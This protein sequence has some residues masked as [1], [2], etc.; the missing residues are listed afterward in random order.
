MSFKV[1]TGFI[2]LVLCGLCVP[3]FGQTPEIEPQTPEVEQQTPDGEQD[4]GVVL[5]RAQEE[6][7]G[8]EEQILREEERLARI[9]GELTQLRRQHSILSS[10]QS[11]FELG[12]EL[13]TSGSI[14]WAKDAFMSVIE[15]FP[16]SEYYYPALFRLELI[17]FELQDYEATVSSYETLRESSPGFEYIDIAVIVGSL[18][19][20]HMGEYEN[21]RTELLLIAPTSENIALANYLKAVTYVAE[22]NNDAA[23]S[24]LQLVVDQAGRNQNGIADRARIAI[25]QIYVDQG[26]LEESIEEYEKV[27]PFSAY[28]DVAMLGLTWTLMRQE[29]YQDAYNL[30]ERVTEEVPGTE[31]FSEFELVMANCALGAQD[32]DIAISMYRQL[33]DDY[34]TSGDFYEAFL[35]GQDV[36]DQYETE[37]ERLDRIRLGLTELKEEAYLQGDMEL[38]ALIEEEETSLRGLFVDISGFEAS[39]SMPVNMDSET[40]QQEIN[41]LITT[42]RADSERLAIEIASTQE[43]AQSAGT[44]TDRQELL[45]LEQE[46]SRLRLALQDLASKMD[47]GM[48]ADHDWMQEA[49]Y[50][51]AI[52]TFMERELKR[53]SLNYLG[54]YYTS[55]IEESYAANDSI[56]AEGFV[57]QK[58]AETLA[59]QRR[60]DE[61]GIE[62]ASYFEEYLAHY[63][64]TRFTPDILVRL[65]QLY[66][67]IDK[68]SYLDRVASSGGDFIPADYSRTIELYQRVL[69]QYAD[70]EVE[71]IALYSLGYALNEMGDP[72]GSIANYRRLLAQYPNSPL[73]PETY[74]RA[75]DFYFDS[76]EFD[77]AYVFY[78]EVLNYSDASSTIY[79]FG[80]YKLGW[81]AYLLNEYEHSI[82]LFGYLIRDSRRMDDLGLRRNTN[83][84]NEAIEY[85]AHDFMEQKS[86]LPVTLATN[87]LDDYED[88]E[89]TV[90][91]LTQMG[92]FYIEQGFWLEAIESYQA[93]L[94]RDPYSSQAPFIQS[95]IAVAYEGAGDYANATLARE[96]IVDKYGAQSE[97]AIASGDSTVFAEVDSLRAAALEYSIGYYAQQIA[98]AGADPQVTSRSY[99]TLIGKIELYLGEYSDSRLAYDFR[100]LLGD[101][102]YNTGNFSRAGDVYMEVLYDSTS[103]LQREHAAGNAFSSYFEAYNQAAPDSLYLRGKMHEVAMYYADNYPSGEFAA[104]FLFADATTHY[105]ALDYAT[106]RESYLRTF[107][108]YSSSEY[109]ARSAR[110]LAA[111]YEAEQM[112]TDAEIWYGRAADAAA[113]TGEDL[114]ADVEQLAGAM[115][116]R[117]AETLAESEDTPTLL[118]AAARFEE[119]ARA[120]P[121]TEVAPVSL[122]D[123]GETYGKAGDITNAIRVFQELANTYPESPLASEGMQRAAFLA[124]EAELFILAGDTYL[125][126]YNR[127]PTA[128]GMYASL[129][130][131]AVAYEQGDAI[132]L[133][134]SVYDKII[135]EQAA[136]PETMVIALGKYGDYLYDSGDFSGAREMYQKCIDNFDMYREGSASYAAKGAFR[137]GEIIRLEYDRMTTNTETVA[138]KSQIKTEIEGWYGKSIT[139]N[140]DIWFMASCARAGELFED[141]ANSVAFMDPPAGL[142]EAATDQFYSD[143]YVGFYE[144][145][146]QRATDIYITAIEKAVSAGVSNEWVEKAAANLELIAP[147]TVASLGLPGYSVQPIEQQPP[148]VTPEGEPSVPGVEDGFVDQAPGEEIVQ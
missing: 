43:I 39:L 94:V 26:M 91:V 124:M 20:Y 137:I 17:Y 148:V 141:F 83:M 123:A 79:Q 10:A 25:A 65:A 44:E 143:L 21:A 28:Y 35:T 125:E 11:A 133:A 32:I 98:A 27:S 132:A 105:N 34:G 56:R 104:Q 72:A 113:I 140:V 13:Y 82:A 117:D 41:R 74:V 51:I 18:A 111:A 118:I 67:E 96:T 77:S 100:F 109:T 38:V 45:L 59:L 54:A 1:R 50:G 107:N 144:P 55:R 63:P 80:I 115:A 71:D 8:L 23:V 61:S 9:E 147:G 101:S 130:S 69:N 64:E 119:S 37:R 7:S 30:A 62:C 12:E 6:L 122:F 114:G 4:T 85:L 68:N 52:A 121:G 112:Y 70:S 116:Y 22:G 102:Y 97:W 48:A 24:E 73:A 19:K 126:A 131:A 145:Q 40:M 99:T 14:V 16:E 33:M 108:Q 110:F 138:L 136:S 84:I 31:L 88:M 29:R 87:F 3:A 36:S 128:E 142:D 2:F 60:I 42:S 75:G 78:N 81:T 92:D 89:V 129:Y 53:D 58:L 57:Q 47:S 49:Q 15:N 46:V 103:A 5:L 127:F 106:A 135:R 146:M 134:M 90:A 95:R 93:L 120:H 66:Y 76:F 139:Y 86:G